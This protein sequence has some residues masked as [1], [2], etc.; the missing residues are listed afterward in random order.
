MVAAV[1]GGCSGVASLRTN[2]I[3]DATI[4]ACAM[5]EATSDS[6]VRPRVAD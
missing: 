1:S 6:A 2:R 5:T 3:A 4:S